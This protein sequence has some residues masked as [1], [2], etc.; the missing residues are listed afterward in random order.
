[1]FWMQVVLATQWQVCA[2]P[3]LGRGREEEGARNLLLLYQYR[4]NLHTPLRVQGTEA[5][6]HWIH[7]KAA[8]E[9]MTSDLANF[10]LP[11]PAFNEQQSPWPHL[12]RP[13]LTNH[14]CLWG[15]LSCWV[16]MSMLCIYHLPL[17]ANLLMLLSQTT[18]ILIFSSVD[19]SEREDH[20][21]LYLLNI[22]SLT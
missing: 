8:F 18:H 12:S 20:L 2:Q 14:Q 11:L 21:D 13:I 6:W 19:G 17:S 10:C 16:E 1:M 22:F 15:L 3:S 7:R 4:T 5:I 9:I